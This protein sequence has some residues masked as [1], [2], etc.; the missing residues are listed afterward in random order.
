[1]NCICVCLKCSFSWITGIPHCT[2]SIT[3]NA[4]CFLLCKTISSKLLCKRTKKSPCSFSTFPCQLSNL[5]KSSDNK[6]PWAWLFQFA[7]SLQPWK[8]VFP[9]N[10]LKT[11]LYL[12]WIGDFCTLAFF[13]DS[14]QIT[15]LS[16]YPAT[17]I[18]WT[19]FPDLPKKNARL[20]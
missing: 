5:T 3:R 10:L 4:K 20:Y 12:K 15:G 6:T 17:Q 8:A 2:F 19:L 1:M 16:S 13:T 7:L 18:C 9:L 11:F 14:P